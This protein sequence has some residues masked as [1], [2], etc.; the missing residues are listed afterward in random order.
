MRYPWRPLHDVE[1]V[2]GLW[3]LVFRLLFQVK[4]AHSRDQE[5]DH[6][7]DDDERNEHHDDLPDT[8]PYS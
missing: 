3:P 2:R 8:Y 5:G 4:Y 1:V 7:A 6:L